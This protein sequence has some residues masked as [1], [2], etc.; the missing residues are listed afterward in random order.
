MGCINVTTQFH[1]RRELGWASPVSLDPD[2]RAHAA[3][4]R[5]S[6]TRLWPT[7]ACAA[8]IK[9]SR[10]ECANATKLHRKFGEPRAPLRLRGQRTVFYVVVVGVVQRKILE[11][12]CGD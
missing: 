11:Q 2:T 8:F 3:R 6:C 1:R 12:P 10:M 4:T 9:E 5:I 7:T